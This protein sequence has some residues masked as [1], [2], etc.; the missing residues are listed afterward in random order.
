MRIYL[1]PNGRTDY[2][3]R[4]TY[5]LKKSNELVSIKRKY[6]EELVVKNLNDELDGFAFYFRDMILGLFLLV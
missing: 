2:T 5:Y 3:L 4:D 6:S 1:I